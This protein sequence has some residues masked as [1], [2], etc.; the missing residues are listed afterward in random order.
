MRYYKKKEEIDRRK[1]DIQ[2]IGESLKALMKA[3][4]LQGKLSEVHIVQSWEKIMGKPIALKTQELYFKDHK[5]FVRL[6][7]APLKHELNMSKKK[8][9]ELLN[10]EVGDEIVK[11]VIFL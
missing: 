11:D 5:L 1:A 8:V 9:I 3:Y 7:S 6:T 4:R 2:P 10:L